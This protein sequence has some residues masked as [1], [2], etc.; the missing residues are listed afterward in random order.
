M[1]TSQLTK[2]ISRSIAPLCF[3]F[4]FASF[5]ASRGNQLPTQ[6]KRWEVGEKKNTLST[7]APQQTQASWSRVQNILPWKDGLAVGSLCNCH[8]TLSV[9]KGTL[10]NG[11][12]FS[13]TRSE[14]LRLLRTDINYAKN[15]SN[16]VLSLNL[17]FCLSV[18]KS[19]TM[20]YSLTLRSTCAL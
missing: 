7:P 16:H 11:T 8:A 18:G 19:C 20:P 15:S 12:S 13:V 2:G 14:L 1:S 10:G 17:V 4:L 3:E 5:W 9:P 6:G